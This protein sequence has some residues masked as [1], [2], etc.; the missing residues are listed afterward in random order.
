MLKRFHKKNIKKKILLELKKS[1]QNERFFIASR[2]CFKKSD[3]LC[4]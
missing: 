2:T 4:N 1:P 3:Y